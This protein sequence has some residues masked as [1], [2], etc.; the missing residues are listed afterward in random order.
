MFWMG[1]ECILR[2]RPNV[3]VDTQ[4]CA[5]AYPWF[6]LA[7]V[8]IVAYV[9]YPFISSDMLSAVS[10][11]CVAVNNSPAV[12]RSGI[13][14][15]IKLQYYRLVAAAYSLCGTTV[16]LAMANSTWTRNH[17]ISLW[18]W[19]ECRLVY[20]PCDLSKMQA[21]DTQQEREPIIFS[22][23]QFRPE[24]GLPTQVHILKRLLDLRPE[25]RGGVKLVLFGGCR[26]SADRARAASIEA[27]AKDLQVQ[28]LS[29]PVDGDH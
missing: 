5:F 21:F 18:R 11:G 7:A 1:L 24:K 6:W 2:F 8:P 19:T 16:D 12:A 9:H 14:S 26:N 17:I 23:A 4:G 3:V 10:D 22:L 20:P 28:V 27:L 25:W 15:R 13:L 29:L